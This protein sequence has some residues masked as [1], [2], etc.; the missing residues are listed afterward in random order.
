MKLGG[1]MDMV[2]IVVSVDIARQQKLV[3]I[4]IANPGLERKQL[5]N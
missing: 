3:E 1:G 5:P 2:D 4:K